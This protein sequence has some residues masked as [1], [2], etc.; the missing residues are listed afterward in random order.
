MWCGTALEQWH[1]APEPSH[2]F[3]L[4]LRQQARSLLKLAASTE[5][6]PRIKSQAIEGPNAPQQLAA[7]EMLALSGDPKVLYILSEY[8]ANG[9][10]VARRL[11]AARSLSRFDS[12]AGFTAA[13]LRLMTKYEG[14]P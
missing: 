8:L 5:T 10:S 4:Q 9:A 3:P 1:P 13:T 2:E 7:I 11:V 14:R 6:E 12:A